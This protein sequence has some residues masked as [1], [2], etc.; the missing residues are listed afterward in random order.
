MNPVTVVGAGFSGLT[1]AHALT[2]LGVPVRIVEK[3]PKPGGL[4]ST[5]A[6][7]YGLVETAANALLVDADIEKLFAD[8]NLEFAVPQKARKNRY[9]FWGRPNRWPLSLWTT[10]KLFKLPLA[11]ALGWRSVEPQPGESVE[12]WATRVINAE[13]C[14]RLL[15]PALQGVYAGDPKR[16]SARLTLAR[17]FATS[18]PRGTRRG[19]MAPVQ[20]MGQLM[21][22]LSERLEKLG[23]S[24][25]Y[26][27]E[28]QLERTLASPV[29]LCTSAWA[30]A[31]LTRATRPE[32]SERLVQCESLPL[33]TVTAFFIPQS[34]DIRG[35]GCLFP[36]R[37][38][39]HALGVLFND[40]IFSDRS[41]Q[42]S[43]TWIFGG[44]H[45]RE[46]TERDDR[47]L[48]DHLRLDRTRL[49]GRNDMPLAT[50]ITR[51]PRA[52]PHYTVE[53]EQSLRTL[54]VDRPLFLHGNYLGALG[55]AQIYQR[56]LILA[57][58]LKEL[59]AG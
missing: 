58:E 27:H 23:V 39:F 28:F 25:D 21:H 15:A 50:H 48:I 40:C 5:Q 46:V 9:V 38:K 32:L 26:N 36:T 30:A 24:I 54:S 56:S 37:E 1:L 47:A 19:S 51:W 2:E 17:L 53:W 49:R 12:A 6:T 11:R 3:G 10:L 52:L 13:F 41:T 42:R 59:Y 20:G 45:D 31:A 18:A 44:A 34:K 43:E 33:A 35:F 8:L 4:L 55:L 22:A 7:K 29:V 16:M 57:R 14:E